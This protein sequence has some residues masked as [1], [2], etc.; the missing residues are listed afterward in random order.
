MIDGSQGYKSGR[1]H[2]CFSCPPLHLSTCIMGELSSTAI[3]NTTTVAVAAT[4]PRFVRFRNLFR[5][6][7]EFSKV[8]LRLYEIRE[9][10]Y[11]S[12]LR[13][14]VV[15]GLNDVD[16]VRTYVF[17]EKDVTYEHLLGKNITMDSDGGICEE[18]RTC[19]SDFA[20]VQSQN[21][22][23]NFYLC[24]RWGVLCAVLLFLIIIRYVVIQINM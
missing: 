10:T 13:L 24:G 22:G 4:A 23:K 16:R 15:D 18:G 8:S 7:G 12:E 21:F 11:S 14:I 1:F 3:A 17:V 5:R 20:L 6:F 2:L 19:V 9:S